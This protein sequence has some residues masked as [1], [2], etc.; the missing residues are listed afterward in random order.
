M[1]LA[2]PAGNRESEA[3]R[4]ELD[5]QGHGGFQRSVTFG[6]DGGIGRRSRLKIYRRKS[7]GFESP[8]GYHLNS[9]RLSIIQV[10]PYTVYAQS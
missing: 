1:G 10:A 5:L 2:S 7:W 4:R 6:P 9:K 8:P 3:D